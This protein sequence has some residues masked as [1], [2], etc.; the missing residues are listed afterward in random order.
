MY[1]RLLATLALSLAAFAASSQ[2][3]DVVRPSVGA[4]A[5]LHALFDRE[6]QRDLEED[7]LAATAV[8]D[9]R[10]DD[11]W[12]DLS[13]QAR[14]RS[15]ARDAEVLEELA[16]IGRASLP[17]GEQLNYDLFRREYVTRLA[18]WPFRVDC[19]ALSARGGVQSLNE[20]A[21][22]MPFATVADYEH[23][24]KRLERLPA[25]LEQE[26]VLLKSCA[27]EKR[28]QPRFLMERVLP[29]LAL[30]MVDEPQKSP[31][32]SAFLEFP[33][34]IP[35]AERERILAHA[36]E[37][38]AGAV[39]PAYRRFDAF[40]REEYLPAARTVAGIHDLPDGRRFYQ[41]RIEYF[42]TTT[43]TPKEIHELGLREV[44]RIR[45]E[46]E[47][48]MREV[49]FHGTLG[50]FFTFLR[51]DP[52][53]FFTTGEELE[54]EYRVTLTRIEPEL[55]H[56]FGKLYRLPVGVRAI[57]ATS[58]PNTTTA[59][60]QQG[61]V[62]GSRAGYYY[63]NL[64]RPEVRPKYEI[65]VLTSH[66]AVPGH[67][68]QI[69]LAQELTDLPEF[70][71]TAGYT[72][73]VEGWALYS[74]RLGYDLGLYKD[75]YSRFGQLTYDMWRAV[76]LVVDT[77]IHEYG[78]TR[79][80]AIDYFKANAAKTE[81]DI[82]NEVDRY[83]GWPGQ[84]LAYKIGQLKILEL[85]AQAEH[86]LGSAFDVRAFHDELL[87]AG[88]LPLDVLQGRMQAWVAHRKAAGTATP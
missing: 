4:G 61:A 45:G 48:V 20:T 66:E 28:T 32:F 79:E 21:E 80:R 15:H 24:L 18:E 52:R 11:R 54:R 78:W 84:A 1:L 82:L 12:P 17:A 43:L 26:T 69:S 35:A 81:A 10:Y 88:A 59:Y 9:H 13:A 55:V 42:T 38:I 46:M 7:P 41:N 63:V 31:Y 22:S 83:I 71:R 27:A 86:A 16:R 58:A 5:R 29:Q 2:A 77:G 40:F 68:L 49:A 76:R 3:R 73:Y 64:Y 50:E 70:R 25:M 65:E 57:A 39:V 19:Y 75:P 23:W 30:Q 60:Y 67:H 44:A 74:E 34:D 62:D 72:A 36:R 47:T 85:R 14:E 87:G 8:G 51:T 37:L 6:W 33:R 56:Q 53:F